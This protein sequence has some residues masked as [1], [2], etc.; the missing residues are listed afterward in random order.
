M[1]GTATSFP[2]GGR[3]VAYGFGCYKRG[4]VEL[5]LRSRIFHPQIIF[6]FPCVLF[7]FHPLGK[8]AGEKGG[9]S[10]V[11]SMFHPSRSAG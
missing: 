1:C 3:D 10:G 4:G 11:M 6:D 9:F 5:E 2:A 8:I 7:L